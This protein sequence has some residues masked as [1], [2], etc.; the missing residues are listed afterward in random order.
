MIIGFEDAFSE[1]QADYVSLSLEFVNNEADVIY[2]FIYQ[3]AEMRTFNAFFRKDGAIKTVVDFG[4]SDLIG[5]FFQL[6]VQD[7]EKLL[8]VSQKYEHPCPNE[9]KMVYNVKTGSF[10]A[11]YGYRDYSVADDID[12]DE[13]FV[14]WLNE[15]RSK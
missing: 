4:S 8:D 6:G 9:I 10:D 7:I 14:Q 11:K 13:V 3:N 2:L 1:V 12:P 15:E 5:Q